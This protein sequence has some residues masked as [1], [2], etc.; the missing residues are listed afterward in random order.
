MA[1]FDPPQGHK[2]D[3][4]ESVPENLFCRKCNLVARKLSA[5][6][7]CGESYCHACINMVR[8]KDK[9][10]PECEEQEF[11]L[12]ELPKYQKQIKS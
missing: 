7:C 2:L 8:E 4:L 6:T 12:F 3:L 9:P 10:C 11:S 1:A 5:T